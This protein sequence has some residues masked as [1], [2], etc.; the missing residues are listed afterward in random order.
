MAAALPSRGVDADTGRRRAAVYASVL[1]GW[2]NDAFAYMARTAC[3]TL[4]W[5]PTP[6][7]CLDILATYPA[8]VDDRAVALRLCQDYQHDR[9]ETWA[10]NVR[11]GSPIGDVPARWLR[12]AVEHG[13]VRRLEDG[14]H[15]SRAHYHGPL[16]P[17]PAADDRMSI[18]RFMP[19]ADEVAL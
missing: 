16:K 12:I 8:P 17:V 15:V 11:A 18:A 9:F 6:K 13:F 10:A 4:D 7:Q 2:T 14:S 3:Q 19:T 5:F 1:A